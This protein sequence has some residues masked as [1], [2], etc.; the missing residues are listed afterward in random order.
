[1]AH[2]T[3]N[4]L[5][6][7]KIARTIG[8]A[9]VDLGKL[10]TSIKV[11]PLSKY[12]PMYINKTG[13]DVVDNDY[14]AARFGVFGPAF[15]SVNNLKTESLDWT[16]ERPA[17]PYFRIKDFLGYFHDAIPCFMQAAGATFVLD[18]VQTAPDTFPFYL[19]FGDGS[20]YKK[21]KPFVA[22]G[23]IGTGTALSADDL[24]YNLAAEDINFFDGSAYHKLMDPNYSTY[25]GLVIFPSSGNGSPTLLFPT[26]TS[27][28]LTN[29]GILENDMFKIQTGSLNLSIGDYIAV[30]CAR[31]TEDDL[32]AYYYFPV[33]STPKYPARFN[34]RVGGLERYPIQYMGIS[35]VIPGTDPEDHIYSTTS[36][37]TTSTDVYLKVRVHNNS[38]KPL[39]IV[40]NGNVKFSM[41]VDLEGSVEDLQTGNTRTIPASSSSTAVRNT[42]TLLVDND[43]TIPNGSHGVLYFKIEKI[44]QDD[45][46][47]T[48]I[49]VASGYVKVKP[50]LKFRNNGTNFPIY[51]NGSAPEYT[52]N[53]G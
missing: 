10:C 18:L 38:G 40:K 20:Q 11:N 31:R 26:E 3:A 52:V 17:A 46:T 14:S 32:P 13:A 29:Q 28:P 50:I 6:I 19:L 33:Y 8:H 21:N 12:K 37:N 2:L 27:Y 45:E 16:Y 25:L 47:V 4:D 24:A 51:N 35:A 23:G 36:I 43:V 42:M 48:A 30:A 9:T 53:W 39:T 5:N 41:H 22:G 7:Y 15:T 1:M 44:W 49:G 34:L